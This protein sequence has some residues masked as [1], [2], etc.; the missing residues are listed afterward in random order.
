MG[1]CLADSVTLRL[2]VDGRQAKCHS[3]DLEGCLG[4]HPIVLRI[5][6][7]EIASTAGDILAQH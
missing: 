4:C 1:H 5:T 7:T 3:N 6:Y 2:S